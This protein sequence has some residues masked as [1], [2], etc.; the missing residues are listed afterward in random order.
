MLCGPGG[1]PKHGMLVQ[2]YPGL[3]FRV[4]HQTVLYRGYSITRRLNVECR[5]NKRGNLAHSRYIYIYDYF[6]FDCL[7]SET[8]KP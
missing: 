5:G 2:D 6:T 7:Q 3:L 4:L 1:A 8:F